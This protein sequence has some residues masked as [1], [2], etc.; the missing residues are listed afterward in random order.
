MSPDWEYSGII[1]WQPHSKARPQ[2]SRGGRRTHQ[3]P[4]DK[5]A[6]ARTRQFFAQDVIEV[7]VPLLRDNV[8]VTLKFYRATAQIV[9]CDNLIKHFLDSANG[10]LFV[11]DQQ[12]TKISAELH[13]DR[14]NPRTEF[15]VV[16]HRDT[17][18]LRHPKL[19]TPE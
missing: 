4:R 13:L 10:M 2:V 15:R 12:V 7:G 3:D 17:T 18:M 19:K 5:A 14:I 6:E 9:D 16:E 1:P 8:A 11:D